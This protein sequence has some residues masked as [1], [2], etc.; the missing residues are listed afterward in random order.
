ME[1]GGT[2]F[3][4][5]QESSELNMKP[6]PRVSNQV[7]LRLDEIQPAKPLTDNQKQKKKLL[8]KSNS[9]NGTL[10]SHPIQAVLEENK[11]A[12]EARNKD[13]SAANQNA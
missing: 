5:R 8:I 2:D 7:Q 3:L 10:P 4:I 1:A 13:D 11:N 9:Q 6:A 12:S